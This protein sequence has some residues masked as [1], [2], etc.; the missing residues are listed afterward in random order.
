MV[1]EHIRDITER[2]KMEE[3]ILKSQRLESLGVLAGGIAH[4]F[5]NLLTGVLGNISLAKLFLD[6]E[7]RAFERLAQAEKASERTK[8]LTRQ[9]LTFSKG[10]A[11]IKKAASISRIIAESANLVLSGSNV[12]CEYNLPEDLWT[13]EV[14]EGQIS[15]VMGNILLNAAEAM[16]DG[17]T[18]RVGAEKISLGPDNLFPLPE[19]PY[20]CISISDHGVG[21]PKND[22][23][24]I[25]D[26][27]FTTKDQ[28]SG[29]GLTSVFSIMKRHD[30][31]VGVESETGCGTTF[32]LYLPASAEI[33][34]EIESSET[35]QKHRCSGRILVLD[36]EEVVREVA[37]QTLEYLGYEVD[38]CS[39]SAAAVRAYSDAAKSGAPYTFVIMDLTIP[40]GISGKET[41]MKL[42]EIDPDVRGIVSS[43]Y[44]ND[45]ILSS[46]REYGFCGSLTK[47]YNL[48]EVMKTLAEI[49]GCGCVPSGS[50][51]F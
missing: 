19:G 34:A 45:P 12:R 41:M 44:A 25:F 39:D 3:G 27:Y 8:D 31:Y 43:G 28:G 16:P 47:P 23:S 46:Y 49:S 38:V 48:D 11:P 20:L 15:Q 6:P 22:L 33:A 9:L 37:S 29:L 35:P 1:V 10:G 21:I 17:G 42:R 7:S 5:N 14:D 24:K 13:V 18:V 32:Y 51:G 4:D 50:G 40:G 30:G 36:D 26:P 2:K